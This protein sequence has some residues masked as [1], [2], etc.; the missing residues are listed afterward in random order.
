MILT[1]DGLRQGQLVISTAG[2]DQGRH[3]LIW[4][5]LGERFLEVVDGEKHPLDRPKKKNVK[6]VRVT[7]SVATEVEQALLESKPIKDAQIVAAIQRRKNELEEGDRFH[8]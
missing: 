7:M 3:Y 4:N 8:G 2:R 5:T 6:H 1:V